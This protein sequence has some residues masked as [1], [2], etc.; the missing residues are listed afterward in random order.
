MTWKKILKGDAWE[1]EETY[2]K[3][4]DQIVDD[5]AYSDYI[6]VRDPK[7]DEYAE[8]DFDDL[9]GG[10]SYNSLESSLK[11]GSKLHRAV[12]VDGGIKVGNE[13]YSFDPDNEKEIEEAGFEIEYD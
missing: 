10:Y 5:F 8:F 3:R 9:M 1:M 6:T 2:G 13:I 11:S 4:S 7:T 12:T